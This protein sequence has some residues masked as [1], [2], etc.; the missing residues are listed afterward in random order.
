LN[1]YKYP[2]IVIGGGI[3]GLGIIRNLGRNGVDVYCLAE[4]KTEAIYSKYCKKYFIYSDVEHD[5]QKLSKIL[6]EIKNDI[7]EKCVLFPTSDIS[8]INV[9]I[10]NEKQKNPYQFVADSKTTKML[11]E[12]K[13]FYSS[14]QKHNVAYPKTF[15]LTG[16]RDDMSI[17]ENS[18][19]PLIVKPSISQHFAEKF[20]IKGFI[21]HSQ[22]ELI[23][24]LKVTEKQ[25][26]EVIIQEI[27]PGPPTNHYLIDGYFDKNSKP[28]ILFARQR[29]RMWPA[30]LGNSTVCKSV[31]ISE[32]AEMKDT[33]VKYLT[34]IGFRGIFN[35]EFKIDAQDNIAKLLEINARSWWY[36]SFPTSCGVNIIFVAYLDAIGE[37]IE[38]LKNYQTDKKMIYLTEDLKS[39]IF[40]LFN[41]D[42]YSNNL[43]YI[44]NKDVD[45]VL[46]DKH[47][48]KPFLMK[49]LMMF[50]DI[51]S[52]PKNLINL[53]NK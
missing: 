48:A 31:P 19:F 17:I 43:S 1:S 4:K 36:N 12:K 41:R 13:E 26:I 16:A 27:I 7:G 2:A 47:D 49:M 28:L 38:I 20:F 22:K 45:W 50:S 3:N 6:H 53:F 35:A 24:N 10:L 14:L 42:F 44:F 51:A 32:V 39:I 40:N 21:A 23:N 30:P 37:K 46:F 11:I 34:K 15:F 52:H 8:T 33:I 18:N 25:N 9:S 5:M 29:L